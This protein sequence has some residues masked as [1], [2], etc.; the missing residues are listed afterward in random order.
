MQKKSSL[1]Y[2]GSFFYY[3]YQT[4][5]PRPLTNH[6]F[7]SHSHYLSE[8]NLFSHSVIL[9]SFLTKCL[10]WNSFLFHLNMLIKKRL[11]WAQVKPLSDLFLLYGN[12]NYMWYW[13][14][15]FSNDLY[16]SHL[17]VKFILHLLMHHKK[18][19]TKIWI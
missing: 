7:S 11:F 1:H 19:L 16:F 15:A 8:N 17:T 18:L 10:A 5:V 12:T 3:Y 13:Y 4:T 6:V 2:H 14:V 9:I